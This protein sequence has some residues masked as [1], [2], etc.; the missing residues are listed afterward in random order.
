MDN[1]LSFSDLS[2][3]I[4]G[5]DILKSLDLDVPAQS[6]FAIAGVNGAGKSTLIKLALDL[7]RPSKNSEITIFGQSN[8]DI[9]CRN[10]LVYLP[11]KFDVKKSVSGWQYLE[12]IA[13]TYHLSLDK[14]AVGILAER[15]DFSPDRLDSRVGS[16]SKGMVQKLGL[17]SCFML[18]R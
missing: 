18:E 15:F 8:R 13:A 7:I 10:R 17:I 6:Y 14:K 1:A 4:S 3:Q 9:R 16:Y 2:Y 12:F 5:A 11:E